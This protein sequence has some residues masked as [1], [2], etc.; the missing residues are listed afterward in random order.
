MYKRI[1]N[2]D[3]HKM[4]SKVKEK[5]NQILKIKVQNDFCQKLLKNVGQQPR[6]LAFKKSYDMIGS[7]TSSFNKENMKE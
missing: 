1:S 6:L 4:T 3:N 5:K 2:Y 7:T